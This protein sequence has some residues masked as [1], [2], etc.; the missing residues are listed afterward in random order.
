ME[1]IAFIPTTNLS[2]T[3]HASWLASL[4][5]KQMLNIYDACVSDLANALLQSA[6]MLAFIKGKYKGRGPSA[7]KLARRVSFGKQ[8]EA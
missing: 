6:K 3:K 2:E 4:G 5:N 8:T 1:D 7:E